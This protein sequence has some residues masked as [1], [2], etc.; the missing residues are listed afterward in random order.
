MPVC[1]ARKRLKRCLTLAA[2]SVYVA[3]GARERCPT[4]FDIREELLELSNGGG[5]R[6]L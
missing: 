2:Q 4:V 6:L 1:P 5:I 3:T